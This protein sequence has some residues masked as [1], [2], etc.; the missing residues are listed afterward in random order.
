MKYLT[1]KNRDIKISCIGIGTGRFGTRVPNELAYEML[2]LFLEYGGTVIDTA[3]NYYE[4][5]ENGR[6]KSEECIGKWMEKRKIREKVCVTTKGGV[7][8][9]GKEWRISLDRQRL[10]EELK[11][12]LEALRTDYIDIYLLHRDEPGRPVEEIVDTMQYLIE[13]GGI[14]KIGVANWSIDRIIQANDYAKRQGIKIFEVIQTWWSVAE[15]KQEMWDDENTTHMDNLTYRYLEENELIGMAYTSQCK[16]YFQKAINRGY[17]Q[18]D[19]FL[20]KRIETPKNIAV[21]KFLRQYSEKQGVT[22]TELLNGYITSGKVKGIALVSCS[23][24]EQLIDILTHC[25]YQMPLKII[26]E[27]KSIKGEY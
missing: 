11:E 25:D 3:R 26:E 16:G 15:Y 18:V 14:K 8:N 19:P 17:N 1:E 2:D 10:R 24:K 6:G 9:N 27:I 5:V 12:S 22:I 20:R 7:K 21:L 13:V 23:S 4:W